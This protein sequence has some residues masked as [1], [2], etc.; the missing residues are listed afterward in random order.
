MLKITLITASILINVLTVGMS[1]YLVK[2]LIK[3]RNRDFGDY[4]LT[5]MACI[6]TIMSVGLVIAGF[7]GELQIEGINK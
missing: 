6:V 5:F 2:E 7:T 4:T 1:T 3:D